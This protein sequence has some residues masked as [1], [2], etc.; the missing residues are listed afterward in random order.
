MFLDEVRIS[1][2]MMVGEENRGWY[3]AMG[4]LDYERTGI[5]LSISQE[6]TLMDL[7]DM[8]KQ[9]EIDGCPATEDPTVRQQLAQLKVDV[10]VSKYIGLRSLTKRLRKERPG[11]ED[12]I[13]GLFGAELNQ[14]LYD[15]AVQ[16]QG[17]YGQL[18]KGSRHSVQK[19]RWQRSWLYY[20]CYTIAG[21]TAEIR[22][23]I[24]AQR[25]LGLPR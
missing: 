17:S 6:N 15:F 20:R 22:R 12:Y 23:N 7:I 24:I 1:K 19:G 8:A 9:V 5:G 14:R 13:G 10:S 2:D 16:L 25:A 4:T 11:P 18:K 3:V 21:G